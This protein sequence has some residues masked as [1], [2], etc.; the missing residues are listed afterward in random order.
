M[1][2]RIY[3]ITAMLM[4]FAGLPIFTYFS[5]SNEIGAID[6]TGKSWTSFCN[7]TSW[8]NP[9]DVYCE[10]YFNFTAKEDVFW[11]PVD[12]DPYGRSTPYNFDPAIKDWKLERSWGRGWREIPLTKPCTGT[13]C[14]AK[15]DGA[16]AYSVA[17]REGK[18]YK[19]RIRA[20][21]YN[22][23]D[24]ILWSFGLDDPIWFG[25]NI[26]TIYD[27]F[28]SEQEFKTVYDYGYENV[29]LVAYTSCL[30]NSTYIFINNETGVN[31]SITEEIDDWCSVETIRTRDVYGDCLTNSTSIFINNETGI[32]ET[33]S[34]KINVSC[35]IGQEP[36]PSYVVI[37]SYVEIINETICTEE[38]INID[39]QEILYKKYGY[40]CKRDLYEVV[41]DSIIDGDGDKKC[42]SG[43]SCVTFDVRDL[44]FNYELDVPSLE[45][46][47]IE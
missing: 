11:Y 8:D 35:V 18:D 38:G 5:Y 44:I 2:K 17:W 46:I 24:N 36:D 42:E 15:R 12:Y 21:K 31:E 22:S 40:N 30:K 37:G 41:C 14:G 26:E 9:A 7:A 6:I 25:F 29:T 45:K 32:N 47:E 4:V 34:T 1:A 28:I 20:I 43:E 10:S 13:W 23:R 16:T 33:R 39:G 19:V 3:L 27:C